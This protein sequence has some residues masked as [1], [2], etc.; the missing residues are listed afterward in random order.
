MNN[1]PVL[2]YQ[3]QV[4]LWEEELSTEDNE[5]N[6]KACRQLRDEASKLNAGFQRVLYAYLEQGDGLTLSSNYNYCVVLPDATEPGRYRYQT[7]N[8]S[9]FI[10]HTTRDTP[11]EVLLEAYRD[12]FR[13]IESRELIERLCST[14]EW[15]KGSLIN[16][17]VRKVNLGEL[18]HSEANEQ[19]E[20]GLAR[21]DARKTLSV[22][23]F[24]S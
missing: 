13:N 24:A 7:F 1:D 18:S 22:S 3:N 17:L 19:Y 6:R 8:K 12:G 9:G 10:G 4:D 15:E 11:E 14:P 21:I 20:F 16:D 2:Y 5:L 23:T